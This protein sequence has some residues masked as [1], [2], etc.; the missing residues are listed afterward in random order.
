[1]CVCDG[2]YS[3]FF[4]M[5]HPGHILIKAQHKYSNTNNKH[6]RQ[7]VKGAEALPAHVPPVLIISWQA[8]SEKPSLMAQ[9]IMVDGGD[10]DGGRA[11]FC[12]FLKM[13]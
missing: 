12:V 8:P 1:M 10:G 4:F 3:P 9:V 13:M 6:V 2:I 5:E 11:H 7:Q